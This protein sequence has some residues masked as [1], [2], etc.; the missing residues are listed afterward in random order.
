VS[1]EEVRVV[2]LGE[3]SLHLLWGI[4]YELERLRASLTRVEL[5]LWFLA[6]ALAAGVALLWLR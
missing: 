5:A 2:E 1:E 3:D 6:A 4:A